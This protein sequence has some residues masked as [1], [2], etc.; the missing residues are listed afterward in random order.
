MFFQ[1]VDVTVAHVFLSALL[2]SSA[3]TGC[4]DETGP[5]GKR[6][7]DQTSKRFRAAQFLTLFSV[8]ERRSEEAAARTSG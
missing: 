5:S 3:E 1:F 8:S 2:S 7:P 4:S 6:T